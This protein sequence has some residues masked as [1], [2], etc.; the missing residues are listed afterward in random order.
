[1]L[2]LMVIFSLLSS[3]DL[4]LVKQQQLVC[5]PFGV[6]G[7]CVMVVCCVYSDHT[8]H[9]LPPLWKHSTIILPSSSLPPSLSS[10]PFPPPYSFL[11]SLLLVVPISATPTTLL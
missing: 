7:W 8:H 10:L 9:H 5:G 3:P 1:M 6:M 11:P 4:E 2:N